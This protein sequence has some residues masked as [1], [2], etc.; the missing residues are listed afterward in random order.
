MQQESK[1]FNTAPPNRDT[2]HIQEIERKCVE[3]RRIVERFPEAILEGSR[4]SECKAEFQQ[5]LPRGRYQDPH[6]HLVR[7][8]TIDCA[9]GRERS[10]DFFVAYSADNAESAQRLPILFFLEM[11]KFVWVDAAC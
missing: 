2:R 11:H 1:I 10:Q 3:Y 6:G 5:L 8:E 9:E 7:V 4:L